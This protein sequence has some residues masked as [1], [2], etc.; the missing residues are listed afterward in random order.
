MPFDVAVII[1]TALLLPV[2]LL[3]F[4]TLNHY[5]TYKERV[6]LARLGYTISEL[7]DAN[8]IRQGNRGVLWGGVITM[9]SGL[10]L[11]LGLMPLGPGVWLV[12]GLLP[13]FVGLGMLAIY[14]ITAGSQSRHTPPAIQEPD[15]D[16]SPGVAPAFSD[17]HA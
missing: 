14:F 6:E 13:M 7:N 8:A 4:L 16:D 2:V 9:M 5:L 3:G 12:A 11:L 17:D 1:V 15:V 10:A